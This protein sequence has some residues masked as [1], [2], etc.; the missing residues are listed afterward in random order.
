MAADK[1]RPHDLLEYA[2]LLEWAAGAKSI[3]EIGSRY[4][5]TL[6][7]LAHGMDGKGTIVS[8][9]LPGKFPWGESGSQKDLKANVRM[10]KEEGYDAEVI[11][12]NSH[13]FPVI[14][15]ANYKG[16]FDFIFIDG[17]HTYEGA[18]LDWESYGLRGK[19]VVFHDIV[20]PRPGERQELGVWKLWEE[21]K[22]DY[23][24]EEFIAPDSKMG[25]G[26][27]MLG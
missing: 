5:Y 17:D 8:I 23:K 1:L 13:D 3:L 25:I 22:R 11:L 4:G 14:L 24:T 2:K 6:V 9:D 19:T 21:L 15:E 12:D 18:K 7:D 26:K 20:K 10:L 27:V 16:P